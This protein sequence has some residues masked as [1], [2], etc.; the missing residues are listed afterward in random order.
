MSNKC[1]C[2]EDGE[3][4]KICTIY[5]RNHRIADLERELADAREAIAEFVREYNLAA[6]VW[7]KQPHIARLFDIDKAPRGGD[8]QQ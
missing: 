5:K 2:C 1:R 8:V 4:Q 6:D 3:Y 7:K